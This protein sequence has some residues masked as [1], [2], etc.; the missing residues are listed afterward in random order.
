MILYQY[1]I[2]F[3]KKITILEYFLYQYCDRQVQ[4]IRFL[5]DIVFKKLNVVNHFSSEFS[6]QLMFNLCLCSKYWNK[7]KHFVRGYCRPD[8]T[9]HTS[10]IARSKNGLYHIKHLFACLV[11]NYNTLWALTLYT[12]TKQYVS[13]MLVG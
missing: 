5:V 1:C 12:E 11:I 2:F 3:C 13:V 9:G 6:I 4:E 10:F 7:D 8:C